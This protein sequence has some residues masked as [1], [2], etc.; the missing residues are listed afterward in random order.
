M[1]FHH[2]A[3]DSFRGL[4]RITNL[5]VEIFSGV[6]GHLSASIAYMC[7]LKDPENR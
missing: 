3:Y 7:L 6:A 1:H 4:T 2:N 5:G